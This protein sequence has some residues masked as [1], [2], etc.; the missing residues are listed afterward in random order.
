MV[1]GLTGWGSAVVLVSVF[2]LRVGWWFS[3]LGG[4]LI[5]LAIR[6]DWLLGIFEMRWRAGAKPHRPQSGLLSLTL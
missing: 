4:G 1:N 6:M 3:V 2:M 5:C